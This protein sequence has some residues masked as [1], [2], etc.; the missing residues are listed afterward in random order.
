MQTRHG[1]QWAES[2]RLAI[3]RDKD[4]ADAMVTANGMMQ[5]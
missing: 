5:G 1:E 3:D 2:R 4:V